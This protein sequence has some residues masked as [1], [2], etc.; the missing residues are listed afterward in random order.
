[1]I[2]AMNQ[3]SP[4]KRRIIYVDEKIQ[5]GLLVALVTLEI[6]LII[7]TLWV[8]YIQM[9]EVLDA[10]LY[11]VHFSAG[12]NIYPLLLKI[13]LIG[14]GALIVVNIVVLWIATW[15]WAGYI[16]SIIRPFRELVAKVEKLDF[17]E[18]PPQEVEHKVVDLALE[19]RHSKRRILQKLRMEIT[20]LEKL[21]D[22]SDIEVQRRARVAL[23]SIRDQLPNW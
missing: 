16:D 15:V 23:E 5:R 20:E 4:V 10:N 18:D 3:S 21:G 14:I 6:L 13:G 2:N 8:L 7:S 1:M 17:T 19:W 22:M 9:G 11:R 12:H